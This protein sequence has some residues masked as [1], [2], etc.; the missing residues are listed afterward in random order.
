M[1]WPPVGAKFILRLANGLALTHVR[2]RPCDA[3]CQSVDGFRW[4]HRSWR[5]Y[6]I[7]PESWLFLLI[8][9]IYL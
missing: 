8:S 6:K 1:F 5:G 9:T 4:Q 7:M 2:P 3:S